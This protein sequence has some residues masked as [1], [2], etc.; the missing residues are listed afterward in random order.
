MSSGTG[1]TGRR[2]SIL[3]NTLPVAALE[4]GSVAEDVAVPNSVADAVR[5]TNSFELAPTKSSAPASD[6]DATEKSETVHIEEDDGLSGKIEDASKSGPANGTKSDAVDAA[7]AGQPRELRPWEKGTYWERFKGS[8]TPM[9][10]LTMVNAKPEDHPDG[11]YG[12]VVLA[13]C[14][15][16][17]LFGLVVD[18]G[19]S[20][21]G[22]PAVGCVVLLTVSAIFLVQAWVDVQHGCIPPFLF[23]QRSL[24]RR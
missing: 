15:F 16:V 20:T 21:G 14:F 7:E 11:Y 17:F 8:M 2:P 24:P 10:G 19:H 5:A 4:V 23:L 6:S 3:E 18:S 13:A 12:W 22:Q 9:P 1:P